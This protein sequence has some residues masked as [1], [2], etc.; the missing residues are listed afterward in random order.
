M[1]GDHVWDGG[2]REERQRTRASRVGRVES[3]SGAVEAE[4]T[5]KLG[6]HLLKSSSRMRGKARSSGSKT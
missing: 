5:M 4:A 6:C 2:C 1:G 3:K